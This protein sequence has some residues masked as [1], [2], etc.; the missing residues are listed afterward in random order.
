MSFSLLIVDDD[1]SLITSIK[2]LFHKDGIEIHTARN[3]TQALSLLKKVRIDSAIVDLKMPGISGMEVIKEIKQRSVMTK[4]VMLT[5]HGG[6]SEAVEAMQIG[7][8]DFLQ[9]P[10]SP[11]GLREKI[12]EQI[13][14]WN[15]QCVQD[16]KTAHINRTFSFSDLIGQS[17]VMLELK[18][19]IAT[20]GASDV[21]VLIEGESG[22]GKELVALALHAHSFRKEREMIA[23]DCASLGE[24]LM[25]SELFGQ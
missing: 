15:V 19:L 18:E 6:V 1:S 3:G 5:G 4:V 16:K 7:A 10:H 12:L 17:S 25:Q 8:A 14:Q 9:K 23:V 2:R 21:S 13:E 20:V 22:T 11:E 24:S